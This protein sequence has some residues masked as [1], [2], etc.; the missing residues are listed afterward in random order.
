VFFIT[1]LMASVLL[2]MAFERLIEGLAWS[3]MA[4]IS[5]SIAAA[6]T[7]MPPVAVT[8]CY[9]VFWWLHLLILLSFLIYV[10]QS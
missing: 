4:P 6:F 10:P 3:A 8:V 7:W 1:T 9:Y 5:S 2:T